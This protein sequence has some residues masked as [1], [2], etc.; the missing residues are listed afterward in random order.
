MSMEFMT[1]DKIDAYRNAYESGNEVWTIV[2]QW[3]KFNR[4][5][6]GN[7]VA[8]SAD[9]ISANIAE[10]YG[11]YFKKEKIRF[12]RYSQGSVFET[13][14]WIRKARD[15]S[16]IS[17]EEANQLLLKLETLPKMINRLIQYTN[18]KLKY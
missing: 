18:S 4:W 2:N 3:E 9:S 5:T 6:I 13:I 8:R 11:R 12:Y 7:Q 10:G 16:L 1:L 14:D 17:S 15:R